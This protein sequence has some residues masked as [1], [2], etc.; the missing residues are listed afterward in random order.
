MKQQMRFGSEAP[1]RRTHSPDGM[2]EH[3]QSRIRVTTT[4][5]RHQHH[6]AIMQPEPKSSG[7]A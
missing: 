2:R 5:D 1:G 6:G 7:L 4:S 3:S